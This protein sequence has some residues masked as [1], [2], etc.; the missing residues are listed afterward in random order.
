MTP[1]TD[2]T[3][4]ELAAI[5]DQVSTFRSRV[6]SLADPFLGTDRDDLVTVLHEA[7]R[8]LRSAERGLQRA[9]RALRGRT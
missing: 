8:T 2:S 3:A 5:A 6:A 4:A 9:L 1:P 7:E